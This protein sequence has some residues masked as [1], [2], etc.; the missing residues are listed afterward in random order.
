ML[1]DIIIWC[2]LVFFGIVW[3]G[4]YRCQFQD[5]V[6]PLTRTFGPKGTEKFTDGWGLSHF[7]FY[8]FLTY[9]SPE[10]WF[11][12]FLIGVAWELIEFSIKDR[13]FYLTDCAYV[14]ETEQGQSWW[15]GRMEDIL[16]NA[17]GIA[18]GYALSR[19]SFSS[20]LWMKEKRRRRKM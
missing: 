20:S 10:Y 2:G 13:P 16:M 17:L 8:F 18:A 15:Y 14:L 7:F 3:Y 6:D 5:N 9:Q 4:S 1:S 12:I 11:L 19:Y